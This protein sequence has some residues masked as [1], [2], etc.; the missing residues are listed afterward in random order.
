MKALLHTILDV[1]PIQIDLP[2]ARWFQHNVIALNI[3]SN[4][5]ECVWEALLGYSDTGTPITRVVTKLQPDTANTLREL[6]TLCEA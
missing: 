1:T 6:R 5:H 4:V 3:Y 2:E